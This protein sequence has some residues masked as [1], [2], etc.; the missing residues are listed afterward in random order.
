MFLIAYEF[1]NVRSEMVQEGASQKVLAAVNDI[2]Q[3]L[4]DWAASAPALDQRWSY[5]LTQVEDSAH[6]WNCSVHAYS[7][8]PVPSVWNTYRCLRIMV[9]RAQEALMRALTL[10]ESI[11]AARGLEWSATR[12]AMADDICASI[13]V[14]LGHA[15]SLYSSPSVLV[16]AYNSI[17]PLFHAA[18]C[19]KESIMRSGSAQTETTAGSHFDKTQFAWILGRLDYISNVLGLRSADNIASVLRGRQKDGI[20]V[21]MIQV[22]LNKTAKI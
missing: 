16:T 18:A 21:E 11:S 15:D 9:S 22:T 8:M 6:V 10:Y 1:A 7:Q 2:E 3:R 19:A 17:W 13:P 4:I 5:Q 12:N 20:L 14:Q